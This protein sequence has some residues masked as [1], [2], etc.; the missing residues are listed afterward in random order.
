MPERCNDCNSE[1]RQICDAVFVLRA[2]LV[3]GVGK[4]ADDMVFS[5]QVQEGFGLRTAS[6]RL[7]LQLIGERLAEIGCS[8]EEEVV[9]ERFSAE[10]A[11][12]SAR[13][14]LPKA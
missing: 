11:A 1:Q 12:A 7:G 8:L 6:Q 10:V 13:I 4:I 3:A 14:D 5:G 9:A 2:A